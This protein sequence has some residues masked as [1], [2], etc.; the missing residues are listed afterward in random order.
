MTPKGCFLVRLKQMNGE[1]FLEW[2][3]ACSEICVLSFSRLWGNFSLF[4][5]SFSSWG[6]ALQRVTTERNLHNV[7]IFGGDECY[8]PS[9][10][11]RE[12]PEIGISGREGGA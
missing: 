3:W 10:T 1:F 5:L 4:I 11:T 6:T 9:P 8:P 12:R 7:M 2:C